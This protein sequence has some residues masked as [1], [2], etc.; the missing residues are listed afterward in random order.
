ESALGVLRKDDIGGDIVGTLDVDV[1]R[2][3]VGDV[4]GVGLYTG[5]DVLLGPGGVR[6]NRQSQKNQAAARCG[7]PEGRV[8]KHPRLREAGC[9]IGT[10]AVTPILAPR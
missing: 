4:A 8:R 6:R 1:E 9:L 7:A 3:F 5:E 2:E 10:R